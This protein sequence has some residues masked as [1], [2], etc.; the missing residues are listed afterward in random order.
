MK[1]VE[2]SGQAGVS[3]GKTAERA[4]TVGHELMF[5]RC[6]RAT[7]LLPEGDGESD[8][9]RIIAVSRY[10]SVLSFQRYCRPYTSISAAASTYLHN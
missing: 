8:I 4:F 1:S 10:S 9:P 2:W 5:R 6:K 3:D 7:C